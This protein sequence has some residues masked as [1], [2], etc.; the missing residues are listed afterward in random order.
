LIELGAHARAGTL[1]G[2]LDH[3][4][5]VKKWFCYTINGS[6]M[7]ELAMQAIFCAQFGV[8]VIAYTGDE[9]ACEQAKEYI[10]EIITGAVKRA[11]GR[12]QAYSYEDA[13]QILI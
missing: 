13:D 5:N 9:I 8:P 3:T 1:N 4:I 11:V 10:P 12:N 2:F 7:N 6:E